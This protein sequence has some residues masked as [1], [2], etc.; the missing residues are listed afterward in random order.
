MIDD[1][2][3]ALTPYRIMLAL[4]DAPLLSTLDPDAFDIVCRNLLENALHRGAQNRPVVATLAADGTFTVAN[5]GPAMPPETL[6]R[7]TGRF[8]RAT[9][10]TDRSGLGLAIV[11]AIAARIDRP[12]ALRSPRA[13]SASGLEA[14]FTCLTQTGPTKTGPTPNTDNS[15]AR[16]DLHD[17]TAHALPCY[18]PD[19]H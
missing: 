13:G 12:L 6:A 17:D 1:L 19:K 18:H 2:A 4:P 10:Q 5:D 8:E 11:A 14:V 9:S 7:L 15:P 16:P 3:R